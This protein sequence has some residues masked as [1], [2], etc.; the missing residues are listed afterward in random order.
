MRADELTRSCFTPNTEPLRRFARSDA[1]NVTLQHES[2][3]LEGGDKLGFPLNAL[4]QG[5]NRFRCVAVLEI[6]TLTGE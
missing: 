4:F 3:D 1:G 5:R 2:E 6:V